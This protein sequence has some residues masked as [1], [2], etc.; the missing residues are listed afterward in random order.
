MRQ[1]KPTARGRTDHRIT[2]A[3]KRFLKDVWHALIEDGP[4]GDLDA[5]LRV[6]LLALWVENDRDQAADFQRKG[7]ARRFE[8]IDTVNQRDDTTPVPALARWYRMLHAA[9]AEAVVK[10]ESAAALTMAKALPRNSSVRKKR[11]KRTPRP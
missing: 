3:G 1:G 5:D 6:A 2:A 9:S 11:T 8:S 7:A 10:G 4:S